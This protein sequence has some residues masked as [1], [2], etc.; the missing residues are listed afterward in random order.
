MKYTQDIKMVHKLLT[1]KAERIGLIVTGIFGVM[2]WILMNKLSTIGIDHK[3]TW[4][5]GVT[6]PAINLFWIALLCFHIGLMFLITRSV[7]KDRKKDYGDFIAG[8]VATIGVFALIG[9]TISGIY[10]GTGPIEW[11]FE[12]KNSTLFAVG[13]ILEVL[14]LLYFSFTE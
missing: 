11:L 1:R 4:V 6:T 8:L 12:I 5:T 3:V 14:A 2:M 7:V 9:A 10:L 13:F